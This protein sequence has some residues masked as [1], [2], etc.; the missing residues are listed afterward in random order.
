MRGIARIRLCALLAAVLLLVVVPLTAY[1]APPNPPPQPPQPEQGPPPVVQAAPAWGAPATV[2]SWYGLRL[3]EGPGLAEPIIL[4]LR[5]GET[6][7]PGAG[8]VWE[9]GIA[10]AYVRVYRYGRW[11]E[12]FCA[13]NY[14]ANYQGTV[15]PEDPGGGLKVVA[16]GG[17]RLRGGPGLWYRIYR[18]V[19][20][21]TILQPGGATAWGSGLEWTKV[22]MHGYSYW[23]ASKYLRAVP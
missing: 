10:W 20:Y 16:Y 18:V 4:I 12:G 23:A 2:R 6:V 15:P 22:L 5:N 3:R 13:S 17:L 7:Y 21:G 1:A 11:Y 19:P 14:L 9:Q 8:P